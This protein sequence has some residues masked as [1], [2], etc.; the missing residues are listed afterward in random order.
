MSRTKDRKEQKNREAKEKKEQ[1]KF[2]PPKKRSYIS[3]VAIEK[4]IVFSE[5]DAWSVYRIPS[6]SYEYLSDQARV[7]IAQSYNAMAE[8]LARSGENQFTLTKS[9]LHVLSTY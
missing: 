6:V 7:N 2:T 4:N 1:W 3:A 5:T 8:N 9:S